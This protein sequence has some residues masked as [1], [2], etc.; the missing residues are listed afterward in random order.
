MELK[1]LSNFVNNQSANSTTSF[2]SK[3]DAI[4]KYANIG[5]KLVPLD[6]LSRSPMLAW[7]EI[8]DNPEFW[9]EEKIKE[10][11]NRF[12]NVATTFGKSIIKDAEGRVLY[13]H[14]LDIDSEE[15]LKRVRDLL[16]QEW[17]LKTFVTKTQK[18]CGHHVYWFEHSSQNSPI[19]TEYCK[20]G[21]EFEIKCGKALC[22]LPPSRHRDN[23]LFNYESIGLPDKIMIA[24]WLYD[25]LINELLKD[26]LRPKK[27]TRKAIS[28]TKSDQPALST[29]ENGAK[30]KQEYEESRIMPSI[31]SE[32]QI[33]KSIE[34]LVHYYQ[35][36]T[37]HK[38]AFG[39]SG[40]TF[41]E[42][43]AESSAIQ[44]LQG[45]CEKANDYEEKDDRI[46]TLYRTYDNGAKIGS[47]AIAGKSTL[48]E[49]VMHVS[50]CDEIT[51]DNIIQGALKIWHKDY[52]KQDDERNIIHNASDNTYSKDYDKSGRRSLKDEVITAGIYNPTEYAISV[53]NKTVK[54]DDSLVRGVFYAGC[55]TWSYDP[56]NLVISAPTSE[57]K[58]YTVLETLKYFLSRDVNRIGSMS[59]KVIVRQ[60]SVLVDADTLVPI[61]YKI[62]DLK[63]QIK[64]ESN[65]KLK[66]KLQN[67]LDDLKANSRLLIDLRGKIYVFLEP[68]SVELWNLIKPIM[69]H[70]SLVIEHPYV[71]TGT[72]EGIHVKPLVTLGFPTFIFCTAKDES[73]WEQWDEIVSRSLVMS[74]NM[75]PEKY[76]QANILNAR[77]IGLPS[78]LQELLIISKKEVELA[79]K[80]VQYLK[81]SI[82]EAVSVSNSSSDYTNPT[83]IPY[84]EILGNTLPDEKGSEMRTNR[85]LLLLIRIIS[86]AKSDLRFQ[87]I[88]NDQTLTIANIEDLTEAL[89][90]MQNSSGLPPYKARFFN[91]IIYPLYERKAEEERSK[92]EQPSKEVIIVGNLEGSSILEERLRRVVLTANEI[93]DYYNLKNP[94]SPVNS[95]NLRKKYLN[96]LVIAG[97]LEGLDVREGNTKKVYYPIVAPSEQIN[98]QTQE[99]EEICSI[100]QFFSYHKIITPINYNPFPVKWLIFQILRLWKCGIEI[101]KGHYSLNN[102]IQAIQFLDIEKDHVAIVNPIKGKT[103]D[104][105]TSV[106]AIK[107]NRNRITMRQ[108]AR[109]YNGPTGDLSRHFSRPILANSFNKVFGDLQYIGM[110]RDLKQLNSGFL[111]NSSLS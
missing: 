67:K 17:K 12:H 9:S 39:F 66:Q 91:E 59:T 72:K 100:P 13:L 22:T 5:F 42:G 69:S 31:L 24:D 20:K 77:T 40:L 47:D 88:L 33:E 82:N 80:C 30:S 44:I 103:E 11:A 92:Q 43:I 85:R 55:S 93:C 7:S 15:V 102:Y 104:S 10:S 52:G 37:R 8:Y 3:I 50:N 74:P 64:S 109:K 60:N 4:I 96:E 58:T 36:T 86:L 87:V 6:E 111:L 23:P 70:D 57:G 84:T 2:G 19:T 51:A 107:R 89:H 106:D 98:S 83:W 79:K 18:D 62:D 26:C 41:K 90:I 56:M 68:P 78:S 95:D 54:C 61:Q 73:Q 46:N 97:Y 81:S 110:R 34:Y 65:D 94:K 49:V 99:T 45:I 76:R 27:I 29:I 101:G 75:S 21:H 35:H 32:D 28:D 38:F 25:N 53:I 48:K 1:N 16:E 71:E 63:S 108:F 105:T 14:C